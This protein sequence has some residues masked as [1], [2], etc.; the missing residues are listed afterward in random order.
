M[1]EKSVSGMTNMRILTAKQG[2]YHI[3]CIVYTH[4]FQTPVYHSDSLFLTIK[5]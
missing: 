5:I 1:L 3:Y 4:K 2:I